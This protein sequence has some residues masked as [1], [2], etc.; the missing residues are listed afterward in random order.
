M[1]QQMAEAA[2][3]LVSPTYEQPQAQLQHAQKKLAEHLADPSRPLNLEGINA[4]GQ[5]EG[6]GLSARRR[7]FG[8]VEE[9]A[10]DP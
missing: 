1:R 10:Q 4:D 6:Q 7:P 3:L 9:D 5:A 2:S 8:L